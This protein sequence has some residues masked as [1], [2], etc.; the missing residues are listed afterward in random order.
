LYEALQAVDPNSLMSVVL[1]L[2]QRGQAIGMAEPTSRG[3]PA[4]PCG[5]AMP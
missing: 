3:L 5:G 1:L 4:E 2:A